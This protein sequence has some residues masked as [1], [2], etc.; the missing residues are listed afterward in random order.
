MGNTKTVGANKLNVENIKSTTKQ[1]WV[2]LSQNQNTEITEMCTN[3]FKGLICSEE[4]LAQKRDTIPRT[5][6][7]LTE[8]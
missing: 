4:H 5:I 8:S 1:P 3:W 7:N 6:K 2:I